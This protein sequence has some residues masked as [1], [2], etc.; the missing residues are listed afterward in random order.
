MKRK[1]LTEQFPFLLPLRK[2][3]KKKCFYL[4]MKWDGERY[5]LQK[6][7]VRLPCLVFS[8]SATLI[9][10]DSGQDIRYQ[11]HKVHNLKLVGE[12]M[13]KIAI[14]PGETFSFWQL[15]RQVREEE[16][17]PAL[18]LQDGKVLP[19]KGGG[20]CLLS[21]LLYWVF[22]HTP[23]TITERHPHSVEAFPSPE[24]EI[25]QGADATVLEGWL[26]LKA[27]NETRLTF[28]LL[29][30]FDADRLSISV[31]SN[32]PPQTRY[33]VTGNA[34]RYYRRG[35]NVYRYTEIWRDTLDA[36]SGSLLA[37]EEICRGETRLCYIPKGVPLPSPPSCV[38]AKGHSI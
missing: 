27:K 34:P 8:A 20:L 2:W 26:D 30:H 35:E 4:K 37:E 7:M 1:Y 16:Y 19:V 5:A 33:E 21:D 23:L 6:R 11:Y 12:Y 15:A 29:L 3:Q 32:Q 38:G 24:G 10:P 17:L 9:N 13:H 25:P 36:Y 31:Y 22:L 14:A 18:A 28:Q